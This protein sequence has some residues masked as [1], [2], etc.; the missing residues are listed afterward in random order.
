MVTLTDLPKE[1]RQKIFLTAVQQEDR[2]VGNTWP[3]TITVL[4]RVCK[5]IR[6]E[7][8]WVLNSWSPLWWL[9][10]P[11]DL[12]AS[13]FLNIDGIKCGPKLD[14]LGISIFNDAE[15]EN[16]RKADWATGYPHLLHPELVEAWSSTVPRLPSGIETVLLDV[17][18]AP[19]WMREEHVGWLHTLLID[20]RTARCFMNAHVH[21][22]SGLVELIHARY[23]SRITIKL[24]GTLSH[25]SNRF[26]AEVIDRCQ[27]KQI[28]VEYVG[29]YVYKYHIQQVVHALAP[30]K[31]TREVKNRQQALRLASLRKVFWSNK[32]ENLFSKACAEGGLDAVREEIRVV[33]EM[34]AD[35]HKTRLEM[36]P[37]G[38]LHRAMVHSIAH[39]M[40]L[41]TASEGDGDNRHVVVTRESV[42]WD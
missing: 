9:Q 12:T 3:K 5:V 19:G 1:L 25:R 26:V 38:N 35:K 11:T 40:G 22:I 20:T 33:A 14:S 8:P 32:S 37:S 23:A 6:R 31:L 2:L 28:I 41:Q 17:T 29:K 24:T 21:D 34:M 7:M 36:P 27:Q 4:F 15:A 13:A 30:K 18:P 39:D 42:S 10:R 16:I